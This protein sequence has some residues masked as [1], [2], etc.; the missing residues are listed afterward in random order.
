MYLLINHA[1]NCVKEHWKFTLPCAFAEKSLLLIVPLRPCCIFAQNVEVGKK[2]N[3]AAAA[4]IDVIFSARN[5]AKAV[6]LL[7]VGIPG[8]RCHY[9]DPTATQKLRS[10][11]VIKST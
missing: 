5:N 3:A 7:H 9:F 11:G 10:A 4:P 8:G 2:C 1:V 6:S